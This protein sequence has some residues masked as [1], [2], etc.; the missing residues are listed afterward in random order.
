[1]CTVHERYYDNVLYQFMFYLLI[2]TSK[3]TCLNCF[4]FDSSSLFLLNL[5]AASRQA[6]TS[7]FISSL[8]TSNQVF[9]WRPLCQSLSIVW[10]L[11]FCFTAVVYI[12]FSFLFLP[13]NLRR[14]LADRH[15]TLP[16]GRRQCTFIKFGQ[17]FGWP[18]PLEISWPQ[19]IKFCVILHNFVTWL[20]ISPERNN[21]SSIAKR[22]CKP[23]TEP[24]TA[25]NRARVLTDSGVLVA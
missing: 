18:L 7:L 12:F 11:A 9:Y 22:H 8:P 3:W 15:Q 10:K 21:T 14:L 6:V 20:Q 2:L 17:K 4:T 23:Q 13:P 5:S 1:M 16:Y 25:K 19:N 24:Q